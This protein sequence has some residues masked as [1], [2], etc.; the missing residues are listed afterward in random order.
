MG[1]YFLV[2]FFMVR[3]KKNLLLLVFLMFGFGL[4]FRILEESKVKYVKYRLY[5]GDIDFVFLLKFEKEIEKEV[6]LE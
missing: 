6:V 3:G 1:E 2:G 4:M 5:D